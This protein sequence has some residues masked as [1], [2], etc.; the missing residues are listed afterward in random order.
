MAERELITQNAII[1]QSNDMIAL[2]DLE[3]KITF[4][5]AAGAK[6]LGSEGPANI[7]GA[8]LHTA[9]QTFAPEAAERVI[10]ESIP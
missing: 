9:I 7:I 2:A 10:N 6:L 8:N 5:N 4:I 3:G 1:H